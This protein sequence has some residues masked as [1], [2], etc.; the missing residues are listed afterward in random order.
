MTRT[1]QHK[2]FPVNYGNSI[3]IWLKSDHWAITATT[4]SR[5]CHSFSVEVI[6]KFK[7]VRKESRLKFRRRRKDLTTAASSMLERQNELIF[8]CSRRLRKDWA[9]NHQVPGTTK[10]RKYWVPQRYC[11]PRTSLSCWED[12]LVVLYKANSWDTD[13]PNLSEQSVRTVNLNLTFKAHFHSIF[14]DPQYSVFPTLPRTASQWN[15]MLLLL[16]LLL[17]LQSIT[18]S[19]DGTVP[20]G[21]RNS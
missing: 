18:N 2:I 19:W 14:P 17:L 12:Y 1:F 6:I 5:T 15:W 10:F 11:D 16:L 4:T 7:V 3:F 9:R 21:P 13:I 20:C 8:A